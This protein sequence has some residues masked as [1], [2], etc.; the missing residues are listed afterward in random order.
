LSSDGREPDAF[1]DRD[2]RVGMTTISGLPAHILLV[3][4]VVVLVP[5]A[6]LLIVLVTTWPAAR[7]RLTTATAIVSVVAAICVPLTTSAG[8]W[9]EHQLPRTALLRTHTALGDTLLPWAIGLALV[10]V[11]VLIREWHAARTANRVGALVAGDSRADSAAVGERWGGRRVSVLLAV[12][13]I[14]VAIG[15]V[16]SVYEIGESGARAAWSGKFGAQPQAMALT[17]AATAG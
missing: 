1:T 7:A 10:A 12:L 8:E 16:V 17:G 4:A 3:H 2:E 11:A 13:A 6:A 9:L 14:V 15:S 5:L